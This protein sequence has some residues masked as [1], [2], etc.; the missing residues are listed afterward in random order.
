MKISVKSSIIAAAV[1][2]I[3]LLCAQ[4]LLG[5]SKLGAVHATTVDLTANRLPTAELLG[6]I[7]AQTTRYRLRAMR[8]VMA[9]ETERLPEIGAQL[10]LSGVKIAELFARYEVGLDRS[11]DHGDRT[12]WIRFRE[13]W[14]TYLPIQEASIAAKRAGDQIR[15]I[16]LIEEGREA[17]LTATAA[18]QVEVVRNAA[19]SG[20]ETRLVGET[21]AAARREVMLFA[22]LAIT[23]GA[24]IAAYVLLHLTKP[25][26][27]FRAAMQ[28]IA[29]GRFETPIPGVRRSDEIG[30]MARTLVYFR[31]TLADAD[32]LRVEQAELDNANLK[33]IA[34]AQQAEL[35]AIEDT[36]SL[37]AELAESL[38]AQVEEKTRHLLEREREIVWRLSRATERRDNDTGAHIVRMGLISGI[39]AE[40]MGLPESDCRMIEIAA[41]MHDV[42]KV[43]IPDEILF[44]PGRLTPDERV[45]METHALLGWEILHGSDSPLIRLAAEVAVSH[46]EKWDGTGYP[47]RL[48]G[49][50]I[51]LVGRI[52]ALADVFD[53]LM[54]VR[55]YKQAWSLDKAAE[56]IEQNSGTHF[57]PACVAAFFSRIEDIIAVIETERDPQTVDVRA[58]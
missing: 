57:D 31:D 4:G 50:A 18:L 58:A 49:E 41:Q 47:H 36:Q 29:A 7:D 35:T 12:G 20:E 43:G 53:A 51:P 56:F 38:D 25:M 3:A 6:E 26:Q 40:A 13:A 14:A 54:A 19:I 16:D 5:L 24:A 11:G 21:Y 27:G 17:F 37:I 42:G 10:S 2:M 44:K 46:H 34:E 15:A 32:R 39:V 52:C 48:A 28:A 45:I 33:M 8:F 23:V 55:P 22:F 30:D 9:P 1:L